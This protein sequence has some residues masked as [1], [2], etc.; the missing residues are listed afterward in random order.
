M[1][2][3]GFAEVNVR[4]NQSREFEHA[5]P[6]SKNVKT[7]IAR[8]GMKVDQ[9]KFSQSLKIETTSCFLTLWFEDHEDQ[10]GENADDGRDAAG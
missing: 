5:L 1:S 2:L 6:R 7:I 9:E 10:V 3:S 8:S 4:V